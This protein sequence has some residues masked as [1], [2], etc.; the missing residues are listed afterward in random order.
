MKEEVIAEFQF[1]GN[2]VTKF[3]LDNRLV[4][5]NEQRA[6]IAYEIDYNVKAVEVLDNKLLGIIEFMVKAKSMIKKKIYFTIDLVM[7]G[8]FACDTQAE[9]ADMFQEMLEINGLF[10]LSQLSRAYILSVTSQSGIPPVIMPML[11]VVK[12]RERKKETAG[13]D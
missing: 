13:V 12:L 5:A 3:S 6:E 9:S 7:E 8:A 11:N 2:R 1:L 10:T 4:K